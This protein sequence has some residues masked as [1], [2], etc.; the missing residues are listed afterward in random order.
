MRIIITADELLELGLWNNF[1]DQ[2]GYNYYAI[3]EGLSPLHE[4]DI[5]LEDAK[6]LGLWDAPLELLE[7]NEFPKGDS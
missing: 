4:F 7:S 1:C 5:S 2:Q 6:S 3:R